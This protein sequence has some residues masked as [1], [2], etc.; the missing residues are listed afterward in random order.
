M[1][2]AVDSAATSQLAIRRVDNRIDFLLGDISLCQL[3]ALAGDRDTH[4]QFPTA[5]VMS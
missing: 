5:I 4:R 3:Q 1:D 2:G